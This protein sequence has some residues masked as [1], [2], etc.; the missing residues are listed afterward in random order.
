M[1]DGRH[2]EETRRGDERWNTLL[3]AATSR[4]TMVKAVAGAAVATTAVGRASGAARAQEAATPGATPSA[5][6]RPNI[7]AIMG[8][9]IGYWNIS[10]YNLGMMG[11]QT[12]NIDRIAQ[13][14]MQF[15]DA[16]GEQSCTAGRAAFIT[17]QIPFR[18]G[19]MKVGMPAAEVG[20]SAED[21]TIAE[22]LKP[23]GYTTGQFGKNHLG[24]RNEFLPTVHGFD[25]FF[26]NLYHLNA[27][28]EPEN[29]EY[30]E[31]QEFRELYGPRGVLHTWAMEEDD[32]T[33]DPRFGRIGKQ[34]IEDTG[35]LT[36]E[37]ME[38]IDEEILSA[39]V[40]FIDR[41]HDADQPFFVWFNST[42]M[43]IW[44][45]LRP[46]SEGATGLGVFA[47]GMTE[48]DGHVG[49]LL[50]KL[51]DLGITE[52]TI[53]IYMTD[54]GA[55]TFSWPDGGTTPFRGEKNSNWEGGF[56]I[57]MLVR[58]PGHIPGGTISNELFSLQDWL[59]TLL[60]AAGEPDISAKLLQ[61]H[62][63]GDKTFNVHIDG[64]NQLDRLTTGVP[65]PRSEFYY[66]S[67]FGDFLGFR[68]DRWKFVFMEQRAEGLDVWFEPF[69][70]LRR[71]LIFDL[72][73]DPFERAFEESGSYDKWLVDH[74][75]LGYP[76]QDY[77]RRFI[78]TF[79]NHP[80]RQVEAKI[81]QIRQV[82]AMME[83]MS[84]D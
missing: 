62:T 51:D 73:A 43:H 19:L 1:G 41:A 72:R 32:P 64:Y 59:P 3:G 4:R 30:P 50:Q 46:E 23:L 11:Y 13:D 49:A 42:R 27:E 9:D 45:H 25:E 33:E 65:S 14:G 20:I 79:I 35:P 83:Q 29:P 66:F 63:V 16:Y 55:E 28:E 76:V 26:G 5:G 78:A 60:A 24:D 7:L 69:V 39:T 67:D 44:S 53:V 31:A 75:F 8:D 2:D 48:H 22:L 18:S 68:Y 38:T 6:G 74:A 36:T 15:T 54:N 80:P 47:D 34:R 58:W 52:N 57:P 10:A 56:R 81:D 40:D 12:P 82:L 37:R 61:G 84:P 77:L 71:P 70:Q 21:P 17:G